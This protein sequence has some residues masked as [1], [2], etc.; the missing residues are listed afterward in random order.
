M[1]VAMTRERDRGYALL[2]AGVAG[3]ALGVPRDEVISET[4]GSSSAAF[5]RQVAMYV[6]HVAFE[7]SLARVADAFGRDRSTVAHACHVIEDRREDDAFDDWIAALEA[8]LREA[9]APQCA[10]MAESNS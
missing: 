7:L 1:S 6:A 3:Y 4:R 10:L 5:A 9:P 2:A 8:S